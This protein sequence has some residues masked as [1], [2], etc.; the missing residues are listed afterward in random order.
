MENKTK[1]ILIRHG[2][3][4]GN[5][6]KTILGHT[7]LDLSELGYRQA[8]V[9][10]NELKNEKIDQIWSSDLKRAY[11]TAIFHAKLRNLEVRTSRNLREVYLGAWE[12]QT[13][14]SIIGKWGREAVEVD[15]LG[16]FGTFSF[17]EGEKIMDAGRRFYNEVYRIACE[18]SGKTVLI[19]AHA[20]VIRAFWSIISGISPDDIA[21]KIPFATNASYSIC[22]LENDQII[23]FEYSIDKHLSE[24][25]ITKVKLI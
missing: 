6:T 8:E 22:Y 15:W 16:N 2:Q 19:A 23:P 5:A 3:S 7:D 1:I 10:S 14:D 25:G 11:N 13:I 12:G 4:L 9:T 17:P 20:A 21:L 18:N 24:V